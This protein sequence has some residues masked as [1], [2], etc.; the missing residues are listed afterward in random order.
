MTMDYLVTQIMDQGL[1]NHRDWYDF[2]WNRTRGIRKD[3]TQQ[4]LCCPHTVSLIEKCTRFHVHCA[5]HLC[6]ERLSSFDAKINNENMTKCL[7]SL[8]EMYEDLATQQ[9]FCPREAEFRQYNVLLKLN[10][11]DILREVQQFRDEVRKSPEVKFAVQAFA[12]VSSNNFVRFFKLVKGASYLS[13]CLLHRYF[14][15]VRSKALKALNMAHTVGP[16]STPFP[17]DDIVRML[18]F[19]SA[20]EATDFILQYGLNVNDGM[21]DLSRTAFQEPEL[22]L[23]LK[24]SEVILAKKTTLI[25]QV[26]NG[27]PLPNPPQ[28]IPVCSFDSQNKY[29]GDGPLAEPSFSYAKGLESSV[30]VEVLVGEVLEQ[31]LKELSASEIKL[32]QERV[33]EEKRRLEEAREALNEKA[34]RFAK[35]T[36][37]IC[38]SLIDET[39]TSNIAHLAEDVLEDE[40]ERIHKFI[41]RLKLPESKSCFSRSVTVSVGTTRW[42]DVVA[43]RRQLKRQMRSFPAAPCCVDPRFKLRALAPSAPAPPSM[44]DLA[45]GLVNLGNG[46]VLAVSS[47]RE[48]AWKPLDLPALAMENIPNLTDRIF[49]KALLLLPSDHEREASLADSPLLEEELI[50]DYM[51]VF[52]PDSTSDLQG[53]KQLTQ[54]IR[55]LLGRSPPPPPLSCQTLVQLIEASL[56]QEFCPRVYSNR[57]NRAAARLPGQD[58]APV[59][60]LYN[61]VLAHVAHGVSSQDLCAL[62]WP[63]AEFSQPETREFVPHLGWNSA[64][65]LSWLQEVILSLQLP[66]WE[67]IPAAG[68]R[69]AKIG[70]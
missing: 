31:M 18:M 51:L 7:Q 38:C 41:K 60:Q 42:R 66:E 69:P 26:V 70:N 16:R 62:S 19:R 67:E 3:I 59:V 57:Q 30:Q 10:D 65:Q 63:P 44:A 28:H 58:A 21:V 64:Q 11:G 13:S 25:G 50:S 52:I 36:E 46:G 27:G 40:L 47:T 37:Q 34:E 14:N 15:Q 54:A 35:C 43:I 49:W 55:W 68:R 32:E 33:A 61:A 8:K 56:S 24:R 6:E 20:A 45:R 39:L 17:V 2:V 23:S 9:T 5:H 48:T 1:D 12:A 4:R 53:S 22:S 29:R